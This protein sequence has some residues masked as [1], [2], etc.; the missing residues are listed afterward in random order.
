MAGQVV[1][2][3]WGSTLVIEKVEELLGKTVIAK[4]EACW[5]SQLKVVRKLVEINV[6]KIVDNRE[7]QL[8]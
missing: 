1:S 6:D 2:H 4:N 3:C 5:N 7:F 8:N